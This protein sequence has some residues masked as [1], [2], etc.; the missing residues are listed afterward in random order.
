MAVQ[1][2]PRA[3]WS[4][5]NRL[6]TGMM[7]AILVTVLVGFARSFFL[8]PLFP[9][10]PSPPEGIF[11]VHGAFF[12]AWVVLLVVQAVLVGAGRTSV[13]RRVGPWGVVLAAAM[14]A[15]GVLGALMAARRPTGFVG[16]PVPPLQFLVVPLT[17]ML[18]FGSFVG[19]AVAKRRDLQAHKRW[20]LLASLNLIT[21][22]IA[23]WPGVI[24][25]GAPP[26]FFGL[27][28]LFLVPLVIWD[29]TSRGRL[30]P[31]TKWGGLIVVVSQPLRLV[32]SGTAAWLSFARWATGLLG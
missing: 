31:A 23:R 19:L 32:V 10:W 7:L 12:T 5:E 21:A 24:T 30:H 1:T 13:H 18:L 25:I 4:G 8:R 22:A 20:M 2:L 26:L 9:A 3:R 17:D 29:L 14:V 16:L 11:Y 15:L 6:Y 28:D 27:T